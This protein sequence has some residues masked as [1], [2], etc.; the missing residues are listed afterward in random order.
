MSFIEQSR[1]DRDRLL[2]QLRQADLRLR[3][4]Q[5]VATLESRFIEMLKLIEAKRKGM[6]GIHPFIYIPMD[7]IYHLFIDVG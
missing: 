7:I 1:L 6:K 5:T 2:E 3:D 4:S